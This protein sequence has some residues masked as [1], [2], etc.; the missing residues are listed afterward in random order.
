[1]SFCFD[2]RCSSSG[3]GRIR[4][5]ARVPLSCRLP[6]VSSIRLCVRLRL[7]RFGLSAGRLVEPGFARCR[8]R[9]RRFSVRFRHLR[10]R[11]LI[12][13]CTELEFLQLILMGKCAA[14]PEIVAILIW[15][16]PRLPWSGRLAT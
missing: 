14:L 5:L 15:V 4:E 8:R 10:R 2:P 11:K 16:E 13:A 9:G 7:H 1:V 3:R 12:G 6:A